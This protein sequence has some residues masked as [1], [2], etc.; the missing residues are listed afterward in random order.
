MINSA[1]AK[2]LCVVQ[3][4]GFVYVSAA[5]HLEIKFDKVSFLDQMQDIVICSKLFVEL[6]WV[7]HIGVLRVSRADILLL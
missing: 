5:L 3:K 1:K 7:Q 6:F 4:T 2:A